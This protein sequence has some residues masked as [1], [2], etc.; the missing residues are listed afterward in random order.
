MVSKIKKGGWM[1]GHDYG[2]R[3]P[4]IEQAVSEFRSI[5]HYLHMIGQQVGAY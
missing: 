4:R 1:C 5:K 2:A 3:H